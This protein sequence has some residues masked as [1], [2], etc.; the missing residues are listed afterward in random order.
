MGDRGK[1]KPSSIEVQRIGEGFARLEIYEP[2]PELA[3]DIDEMMENFDECVE[4]LIEIILGD[5]VGRK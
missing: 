3:Y 2:E 5:R 1:L 4:C